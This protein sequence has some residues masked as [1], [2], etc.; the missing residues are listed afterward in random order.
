MCYES[1]LDA[2]GNRRSVI[3]H[4]KGEMASA[5]T[6]GLVTAALVGVVLATRG[7]AQSLVLTMA[8]AGLILGALLHQA[9][10][11]AGVGIRRVRADPTH[12]RNETGGG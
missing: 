10:L 1:L 4:L 11:V 2:D 6:N 8:L 9:V 5:L 7:V 3:T 12:S